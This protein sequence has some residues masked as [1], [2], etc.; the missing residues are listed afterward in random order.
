MKSAF[1][2]AV[3]AVSGFLGVAVSRRENTLGYHRR[4]LLRALGVTVVLDVGANI[5]QYARLL[6]KARYHGVIVSFEPQEE[7]F[8]QLRNN[9]SGDPLHRCRQV[10]LGDYSG[11]ATLFVSRNSVSSSLRKVTQLSVAANAATAAVGSLRVSVTSLD[12]VF[13]SEVGPTDVCYLKIDTQGF[14]A[15][16]L[17]GAAVVLPRVAAIEIEL[18]LVALY[19]GQALLPAVWKMLDQGNFRPVWVERGFKEPNSGALLQVDGL[20]VKR[21]D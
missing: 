17:K 9:S 13:P 18:S 4:A 19:E 6:R 7:A 21:T 14:E 12:T 20:F 11:D 8:R 5:G 2:S 10:A 15:Q 16:V 3:D 1:Y